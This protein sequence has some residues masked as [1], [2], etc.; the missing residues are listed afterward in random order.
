MFAR[1]DDKAGVDQVVTPAVVKG[2][3]L[4]AE[5]VTPKSPSPV[6]VRAFEGNREDSIGCDCITAGK[7]RQWQGLDRRPV[8]DYEAAGATGRFWADAGVRPTA[9][10][11]CLEVD[12]FAFRWGFDLDRL[13][14]QL[15]G[16]LRDI[17]CAERQIVNPAAG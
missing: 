5:C 6:D 2:R 3:F 4:E 14:P 10:R 15:A 12:A 1:P 8:L 9:H 11:A 16:A 17:G 13:C 7:R